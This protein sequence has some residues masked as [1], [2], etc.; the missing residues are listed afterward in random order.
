MSHSDAYNSSFTKED[1]IGPQ[2]IPNPNRDRSPIR[3]GFDRGGFGGR[4]GPGGGRG[5]GRGGFGG[6][7]GGRGGGRDQGWGPVSGVSY[8]GKRGRDDEDGFDGEQ[9]DPDQGNRY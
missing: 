4:G 8:R 5:G 1:G 6:G 2:G 3:G 7:R 9:Y